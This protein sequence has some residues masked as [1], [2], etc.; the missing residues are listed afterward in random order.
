[1]IFEELALIMGDGSDSD[2]TP[3][4]APNKQLRTRRKMAVPR[5]VTVEVDREEG[6]AKRSKPTRKRTTSQVL[7]NITTDLEVPPK[8]RKRACKPE[9]VYIIPDV[10]KKATTFRG[11]LGT[12][13]V[14]YLFLT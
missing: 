8:K 9:P 7:E 12:N 4:V 1:M 11:R 10:E 14:W 6:Q 3:L 13:Y 2:N 5:K